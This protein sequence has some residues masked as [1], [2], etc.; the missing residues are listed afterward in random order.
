MAGIV[1][2]F[3]Q[4]ELLPLIGQIDIEGPGIYCLSYSG[5]FDVYR[6]ISETLRPIYAGRAV[7]PG[8]RRGDDGDINARS[9]QT[10]IRQHKSS[11]DQAQNL[12]T[13]DFTFRAL[14]IEPA[15]IDLAERA[16]IRY[17]K[18]V[19]NA[20]LDGFGDHN[21]GRGRQSGERSWWDTLHPG[22]PLG[23]KSPTKQDCRTSPR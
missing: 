10:R 13:K 11:I 7:P 9:L 17:Y 14:A 16:I 23:S 20:C 1:S 12:E 4:Q 15:W 8:S 6:P 18:P 2:R 5:E 22:R 3:E 21:P 19:W